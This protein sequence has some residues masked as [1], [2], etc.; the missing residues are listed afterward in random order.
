MREYPQPSDY[1][2]KM[3]GWVKAIKREFPEAKVAL[4]GMLANGATWPQQARPGT[5]ASVPPV[6]LCAGNRSAACRQTNWNKEVL[7]ESE[8][9]KLADA[10]TIH[11]YFGTPQLSRCCETRSRATAI[12]SRSGTKQPARWACRGVPALQRHPDARGPSQL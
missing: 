8:A 9:A 10:A 12:D 7:V 3:L 4:V 1:S 5:H 2:D 6:A 11:V